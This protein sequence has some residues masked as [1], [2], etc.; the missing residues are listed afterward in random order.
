MLLVQQRSVGLA[1]EMPV[2]V[3]IHASAQRAEVGMYQYHLGVH[4]ID[5]VVHPYEVKLL[6][7]CIW[8]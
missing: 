3:M 8:S 7:A 2:L 1:W 4:L 6:Y 5:K